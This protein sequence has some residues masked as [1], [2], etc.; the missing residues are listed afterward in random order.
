MRRY[1]LH[2]KR[3]KN[4]REHRDRQSTQKEFSH[5][6]GIS[7]RKLRMI[8]AGHDSAPLEVVERMADVLGVPK[9]SI[10]LIPPRPPKT[11]TRSIPSIPKMVDPMIYP[12]FSEES[13]SATMDPG[14]LL[15]IGMSS[16]QVLLEIK[17]AL[18]K[19]TEG[20][21][22]ELFGIVKSLSREE[23]GPLE[24]PDGNLQLELRLRLRELLVLLKGNDVW[25]YT[26][27]LHFKFLPE[28]YEPRPFSTRNVC[29]QGIIAFGTPGENG[30]TSIWVRVDNGHPRVDPGGAL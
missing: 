2:G 27:S 19:E 5:L 20:Y 4:L 13:A 10:L 8:E 1:P 9:E 17:G 23:R 26:I 30:E 22:R 15:D 28:S 12:R 24:P 6:V 29:I 14:E 21:A 11:I 25:V 7:E 16:H 18:T 3:I